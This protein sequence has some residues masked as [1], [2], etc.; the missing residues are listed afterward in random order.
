MP[1]SVKRTISFK[2][3]VM[4]VASTL[5]QKTSFANK[6]RTCIYGKCYYC[7]SEDP[8]CEDENFQIT[9]AVI[10]NVKASF[11]SHRSPWQ[12]TYKRDKLAVWEVGN[13]YCRL[14]GCFSA[15]YFVVITDCFNSKI[16]RNKLQ[17]QRIYDLID[18][19]IFDFL[20]Q[21]GDRHHYE[22]MDDIVVFIDNGKGLG[23]PNKTFLDVLA[24]LY[25]CCM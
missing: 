18:V 5:L 25:Q 3:E 19:A 1:L 13:D 8:I 15:I 17:K 24:P 6:N 11:K 14:I 10:V 22:V 12:R 23:N 7:K 9:G 21:N 2:N 16:V 20:L 4:P